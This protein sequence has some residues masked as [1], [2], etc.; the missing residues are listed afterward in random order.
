[1]MQLSLMFVVVTVHC[2]Y[3]TEA[4]E[5]ITNQIKTARKITIRY[6]PKVVPP[7]IRVMHIKLWLTCPYHL[8]KEMAPCPGS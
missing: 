5:K 7:N 6:F 2:K 8:S 1:M 3:Y 4:L